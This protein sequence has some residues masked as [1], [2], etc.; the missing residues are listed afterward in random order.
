M[1]RSL[2]PAACLAAV[3][4]GVAWSDADARLVRFDV[5]ETELV[6]DGEPFGKTGAYEKL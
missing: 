2:I 6:L 3:A 5:Q 4:T 1:N